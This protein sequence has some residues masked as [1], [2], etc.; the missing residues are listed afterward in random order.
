MYSGRH[1]FRKSWTS[2]SLGS[3]KLKRVPG[4]IVWL[5]PELSMP[6]LGVKAGVAP[7]PTQL[8]QLAKL[9]GVLA[10]HDAKVK[11]DG[12]A[13]FPS[14]VGRAINP[15][16][17][18]RIVDASGKRINDLVVKGIGQTQKT[19]ANEFNFSLKEAKVDA[20]VAMNM[21]A[22]GV[23]AYRPVLIFAPDGAP[24]KAIYVRAPD[25]MLR[26]VDASLL[27]PKELKPTLNHLVRTATRMS[28]NRDLTVKSWTE[29][30]LPSKFG[31][32]A[33]KLAKLGITN[34]G[35]RGLD[36]HGLAGEVVDLDGVSIGS[37][38]SD[39]KSFFANALTTAVEQIGQKL[40]G[41][42]DPG[43]AAASFERSYAEGLAS[44]TS[45][46]VLS[47]GTVKG[48]PA[49]SLTKLFAGVDGLPYG[50]GGQQLTYLREKGFVKPGHMK[51]TILQ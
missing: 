26:N 45:R 15:T 42:V 29:Q 19:Y 24:D 38:P 47:E 3:I 37:K 7:T 51:G 4:K 13:V 32:N 6:Q 8:A 11:N 28:G 17:A 31:K 48:L 16:S 41:S 10:V 30:Y 9:F 21:R 49:R 33:G 1:R 23:R 40:P 22:S 39:V 43:Q 12:S 44:S 18:L 25:S 34:Q 27:S 46:I 36:N 50:D 5:N 2:E 35:F 20:D 14:H